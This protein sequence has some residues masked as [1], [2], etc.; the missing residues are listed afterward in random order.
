MP[1]PA[2]RKPKQWKKHVAKMIV[3]AD[4]RRGAR[5]VRWMQALDGKPGPLTHETRKLVAEKKFQSDQAERNRNHLR[6]LIARTIAHANAIKLEE[7]QKPGALEKDL[8]ELFRYDPLYDSARYFAQ[9]NRME[10]AYGP[11]Q[12]ERLIEVASELMTE[13]QKAVANRQK[14]K[15]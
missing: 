8:N 15:R 5:S 12:V 6:L 11:D 9:R 4:T 2:L 3:G 1:H 7:W 14:G 10:S 13:A